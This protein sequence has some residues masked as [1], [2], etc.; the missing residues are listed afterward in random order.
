MNQYTNTIL[1]IPEF[2]VT[3]EATVTKVETAEGK[4]VTETIHG[5]VTSERPGCCP[6]CRNALHI[7]QHL[8]VQLHHLTIGNR[9]IL[10]DV[11]FEQYL[12]IGCKKTV[13]QEI[14]ESSS[15]WNV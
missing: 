5:K 1:H 3:E 14:V 11:G 13:S 15:I 6:H 7:H 9:K 8:Q 10:L 2:Q 4:Q 12:C